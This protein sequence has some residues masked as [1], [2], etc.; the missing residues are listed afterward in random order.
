VRW[1]FGCLC[2]DPLGAVRNAHRPLRGWFLH[3]A[4]R[5]HGLGGDFVMRS[6]A[7]WLTHWIGRPLV[8]LNYDKQRC[9]ADFRFAWCRFRENTRSGT[10]SGRG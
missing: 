5:L 9:E 8:R 1:N 3:H 7:P 6:A 4:A 10:L 2:G